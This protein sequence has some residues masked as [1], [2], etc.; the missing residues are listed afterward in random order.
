MYNQS[1]LKKKIMFILG[2]VAVALI[3]YWLLKRYAGSSNQQVL[4]TQDTQVA[5]QTE[6]N[7]QVLG[8]TDQDLDTKITQAIQTQVFANIP[9]CDPGYVLTYNGTNFVCVA[10]IDTDTNTDNQTLTWDPT[11]YDLSI[12]RG[13]TVNLGVLAQTLTYDPATHIL[14]VSAGNTVDLSDLSQTLFWDGDAN[15]LE[16]SGGNTIDLSELS[17]TL[18]LEDNILT[19]SDSE[20]AVDLSMYLDNTDNQTLTLTGTTLSISGGNSVDFTNWDTDVTDDVTTLNDLLDVDT[21]TVAPVAGNLLTFDGTNWVPTDSSVYTANIYT[22]D[23]TLTANR[24]VDLANNTL[25][26]VNGNIGVG[27]PARTTGTGWVS[28]ERFN[29]SYLT[30]HGYDVAKLIGTGQRIINFL[31][32]VGIGTDTPTQRLDINAN[33]RLRGALYDVN[34]TPGTIGQVLFSTGT[35]VEWVDAT[36]IGYWVRT[37]Q[38]LT[39][40]YPGDAII[41]EGTFGS[42]DDLTVSGQGTRLIWYPKKAAFRVGRVRSDRWDDANI[43][44]YS[45]VTGGYNN[46]AK[47][48]ISTVSG[49]YGNQVVGF[50]SAIG[51]GWEN[52]ARGYFSSIPGGYQNQ[53]WGHYTA[54]SG[55]RRNRV[56]GDFSTII[57][58][59][60][61]L[62]NG[63][64]SAMFGLDS[65]LDAD[66][67]FAGGQNVTVTSDAVNSITVGSN[68]NNAAAAS[69]VFGQEHTVTGTGHLV[70][71]EGNT[72]GR[73]YNA[74]LGAFNKVNSKYSLVQGR[75]NKVVGKYSLV[76]GFKGDVRGAKYSV[77][78]GKNIGLFGDYSVAFGNSVVAAGDYSLAAGAY[79]QANADGSFAVGLRNIANGQMSVAM[80][81]DNYAAEFGSFAL[82]ARNTSWAKKSVALGIENSTQAE[83]SGAVGYQNSTLAKGSFAFGGRN[84]ADGEGAMIIGIDSYANAK[85]STTLGYNNINTSFGS[86]VVGMFNEPFGSADTWAPFD[87]V[88][89]VGNGVDDSHRS[90]ALVVLKAGNVGIGTNMPVFDLQVGS[91]TN[92]KVAAAAAWV[93]YSDARLKTDIKPIEDALGAVT[94][95]NGVR[96]VWENTGEASIGFIAQEV[97]EVLPEVVFRGADGYLSVDYSKI[98]PVLVEAV[99][100]QESKISELSDVLEKVQTILKDTAGLLG[101]LQDF[102][103]IVEGKL[104]F[105]KDVVFEG[106]ATFESSARFMG[107]VVM[108]KRVYNYDKDIAGYAVI[109]KGQRSVTI[110]F[111]KPYPGV[112]VVTATSVDGYSKFYVTDISKYGFTIKLTKAATKDRKFSWSAVYVAGTEL[113]SE[114]TEGTENAGEPA[115]TEAPEPTQTPAPTEIPEPTQ[116]PEP[117]PTTEEGTNNGEATGDQVDEGQT[118]GA[119]STDAGADTTA[120]DTQE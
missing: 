103:K 39:L 59:R 69:A 112:P 87:P 38:T 73:D 5:S 81:V 1:S 13:N 33:M 67:S 44:N 107:S 53:V 100:A 70:A 83:L 88:F 25:T 78:V 79:S 74:V 42:G 101:Q 117:T 80:G 54:I 64:Y 20:S 46:M 65:V 91:I 104:L 108:H 114:D 48:S 36:E 99:K 94:K 18:V 40:R 43:G 58:G 37:G 50:V 22:T 27:V 113:V 23:G 66:Y 30:G 116:T 31:G 57:G 92:P 28:A 16:I 14:G 62:L 84:V 98:T 115:P 11:T 77:G 90:N 55:G 72:V 119:T 6:E 26:F 19:I 106:A 4:G 35:G 34:N 75:K 109:K 105:L 8:V 21:S 111:N 63:Y 93:T 32:Y 95:L 56:N 52:Y 97:Q 85:L 89:V 45:T 9:A 3:I 2:A 61:N 24:T 96:F 86:T 17:Q 60:R 12:E 102:I 15:L 29:G 76:L 120:Q 68:I 47:A 110:K 7:Q 41:A 51:G 82:G 10:D 49:G 118:E 71:G